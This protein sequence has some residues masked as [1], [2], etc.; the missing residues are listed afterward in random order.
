M[1]LLTVIAGPN[2]AGKSTAIAQ[3]NPIGEVVNVDDIARGLEGSGDNRNLRAA[4]VALGRI[5][6]LLAGKADFNYETTLSSNHALNVMSIARH[7]GY[8]VELAYIILRSADLHVARVKQRVAQGGHD[9][10]V[11]VIRRRYDRPLANLPAAVHLS[12]QV[13]VYDNTEPE[14]R[15]VIRRSGTHTTLNTLPRWRTL[16]EQLARSIA[17]AF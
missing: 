12:D 13:V 17:A 5:D 2:G 8:R 9:I 6:D 10:P 14:L 15:A 16:D 1:P 7:S 11:D 4:R 3:L